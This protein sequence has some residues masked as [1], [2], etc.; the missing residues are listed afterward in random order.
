MQITISNYNNIRNLDYEIEDS[1]INFLFGISGCGKSS[2]AK[3]LTKKSSEDNIPYNTENIPFV[4]VNQGSITFNEYEMFDLD[5]MK[6]VLIEKQDGTDIYHIMIG[7]NGELNALKEEYNKYIESLLMQRENIFNIKGKIDTLIN[8]LKISYTRSNDYRNGCIIKKITK[9]LDENKLNYLKSKNYSNKQVKWFSDGKNTD[10]YK[11]GKC[12]FCNKK[13]SDYRKSIIDKITIIDAKSFEKINAQNAIFN[14]LNIKEPNWMKKK[15]VDK[16]NKQIRMYYDLLPQFE[17][18]TQYINVASKTNIFLDKLEKITVTKEMRILYP[19]IANEMDNFNNKYSNIRKKLGKIKSETDKLLKKNRERINDYLNILG[20]PYEFFETN[21]NDDQKNAE[22]IIRAKNSKNTDMQK[23]R[24]NNLSYGE[25]NLIGLIIFLIS[26]KEDDFLIIDDPASSYDEYRRK[27][28]FDMLYKCKGENTT[29]LVLSHDHIFAKYAIYHFEKSKE[30]RYDRLGTLEKLYY[31]Q[32]GKIDYIETYN[33]TIIKPIKKDNFDSMTNFIKERLK[34]LPHEINY[35][36]AI[37]LRL[38]Y[39]INK[40]SRYHKEVYGYLSQIL[41]RKEKSEIIESLEKVNKT[42]NDILS[43]IKDDLKIDYDVLDNEYK[44]G[45]NI[46]S[47]TNFEKLIFARENCSKNKLGKEIKNE[48]NNIV[49]MNMAYAIC[50]NPYEFNYFSKF[51]YN[52][53]KND[54]NITFN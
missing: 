8:D 39:E 23:D 12:P 53:L 20:I 52:Y 46:D 19:E 2:I 9:N 40:A 31:N 50:L 51:V 32:T 11:N 35:L 44:L 43:A 7:N 30:K 22:F 18:L 48:L 41:H 3:A 14:L 49:H 5:Y 1:K 21:I 28:I 38:Y 27:V 4:E 6:R 45:I 10:S 42:E 25:R 26:H 29:M 34:E 15:E 47:M 16:F 36:V 54:L 13:L 33:E 24:V 17:I 37:N